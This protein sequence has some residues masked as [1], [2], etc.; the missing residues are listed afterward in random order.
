ME[1]IINQIS[2]CEKEIVITLSNEE[3]KPFI[4]KAYFEVQPK[5]DMKGFRKG[6]VPMS[7]IRQQFGKSIEFDAKQDA[8]NET[9]QKIVKEEKIKVL[10][11]PILKNME[12][13]DGNSVFTIAFETM[14]DF[15]LGEYR[16]LQ[17]NEPVHRVGDDEIEHE[18]EHLRINY[19]EIKDAD[20]IL[21]DYYIVNMNY[22]NIDES[23][24][25]PVLSDKPQE[26]RA[27]LHNHNL[28]P[29]LREKFMNLKI[30]DNF[31]YLPAPNDIFPPNQMVNVTITEIKEVVPAEL[32]D[33]FANKASNG[34]LDTIED[35]RQ[36]YGF[37]LQEQWDQRSRQAMENQIV[38][39]LVSNHEFSVPPTLLK[40]VLDSMV[41]ETI[42]RYEEYT[43]MQLSLDKEQIAENLR[44]EAVNR[45]KWEIIMSKIIEKENIKLEDYDL[46][47][48]AEA[49]A[50]KY[51]MDV[52]IIKQAIKE[53]DTITANLVS[54]KVMDLIFDFAITNEVDFEEIE[55]HEHEHHDHDHD[56]E[57]DHEH[58]DDE[59]TE[60]E[61]A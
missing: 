51:N 59:E 53:N 28:Y 50:A 25:L 3:I 7:L 41:A 12:E 39:T 14:P 8:S 19:G 52:S 21:S 11:Q 1:K 54:K 10:S 32:N 5:V 15:E 31:N 49:E 26:T 17:L 20:E 24:G 40:E 2:D 29:S 18:I 60:E 35:L 36:E 61:K 4:D 55:A 42:K 13:K 45:V 16:G 38:D 6:K 22:R 34:K 33:E 57:D 48:F 43:K 37:Q 27:F 44:D 56:N 23:T 30:G 47:Q 58:H 46:E 9:F